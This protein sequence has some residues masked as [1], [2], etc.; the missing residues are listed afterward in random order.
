MPLPPAHPSRPTLSDT[1]LASAQNVQAVLAG[2]S[3]S[4]SLSTTPAALRASVQA[5]AFHTLRNL[6]L[7]RE[8]KLLMVKRTPPNQL[9][10]ALLLVSLALLETAIDAAETPPDTSPAR[11]HIPVYA[12]HTVVDQAV[13]VID[14]Q[15]KLQPYKALLNGVLRSYIR[16]RPGILTQARK[17][18]EARYNHPAWWIHR[19]RKAYPDQWQALLAA[20][21]IPGPMT[22]RV[23][24]RRASVA[25]LMTALQDAGISAVSSS[26]HA[27][28]L[29]SPL[30]VHDIPGFDEGWWSVQDMAAQQAAMLLPLT[31]G[32]RVLDACAAP[33]GKTAHILERADVELLALDT[34]PQRLQRIHQNLQ[35]VGLDGD[36]VSTKCADAADPAS[37]WDER[38][39]DAVLADV[40]C[41]A[42]GV[43]RRHPDIRWLRREADIRRT[44]QL[45]GQIIDALWTTVGP[46]G[47][48]LY[49]TCSIF[50]Q[51]GEQQA[52]QFAQRHAD[53]RRLP[54]PG[55][56]L[57]LDGAG[58]VTHDGFF[59]ALFAKTA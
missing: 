8:I 31:P 58:G 30:P 1:I 43:V 28:T 10:D 54:A 52:E 59:Y 11:R 19:L 23:N 35:R 16:E 56:L 57:P 51:E 55:Q 4:D 14:G 38:P 39:F 50:P 12:V 7:A 45:Q 41:T 9:F 36:H 27:I 13:G 37:W 15:K 6:G 18:P 26:E 29:A 3:L 24:A 46:G 25:D 48:M 53:A 17:N 21:N 20:A 40:P 5:V 33:G 49:A 34:D 2:R 32:M 44:A 22:L 42:S 47:H